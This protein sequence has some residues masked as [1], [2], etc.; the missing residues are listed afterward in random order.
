MP[1]TRICTHCSASVKI[2]KSVC[3]CGHVF[4]SKKNPF[5]TKKPR[6]VA[7]NIKMFLESADEASARKSDDSVRKARKHNFE[8]EDVCLQR[9]Q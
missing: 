6:H 7:M 5:A 1:L 2:R 9:K 8:G 3:V 4:A